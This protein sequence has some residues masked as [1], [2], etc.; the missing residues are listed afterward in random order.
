MTFDTTLTTRI[1]KSSIQRAD[2][3]SAPSTNMATTI[4]KWVR[5]INPE[6]FR[7]IP[8]AL[9]TQP[10][11]VQD[12]NY[13]RQPVTVLHVGRLDRT[14][15]IETLARAIPQ[16]VQHYP[17]VRFVYLGGDRPD[18]TGSTW[19]KRLSAYFEANGVMQNVTFTGSVEHDELLAWYARADIAVVPSMLYESFSYT[20]AQAMA[21]GLPVIASRIGGI[22]ETVQDGQYGLLIDVD[23]VPDLTSN[24]CELV[25]K[26]ERRRE[27]GIAAAKH[28]QERFSAETVAEQTLALYQ[29]VI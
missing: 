22:P 16:V 15:G 19:L 24:L 1:E 29:S 9:D 8:N 27:L 18:G 12:R 28:A 17:D 6:N 3:L 14:K 21:A 10:F 4:A 20:V 11:A 25:E 13:E 23:D 2:A 26:P 5:G 7:V